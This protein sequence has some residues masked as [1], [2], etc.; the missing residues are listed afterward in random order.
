MWQRDGRSAAAE[1]G[2]QLD[3]SVCLVCLKCCLVA[4]EPKW[5]LWPWGAEGGFTPHS[6]TLSPQQIITRQYW[7]SH[8][9][10]VPTSLWYFTLIYSVWDLLWT[11]TG[12]LMFYVSKSVLSSWLFVENLLYP[13]LPLNPCL[14]PTVFHV[15][16]WHDLNVIRDFG[17]VIIHCLELKLLSINCSR[18]KINNRQPTKCG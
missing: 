18:L 13:I 3:F 2:E 6:S 15:S 10:L 17:I 5:V 14:C 16:M 11:R 9:L 1:Q 8:T 7:L 4:V 12:Q